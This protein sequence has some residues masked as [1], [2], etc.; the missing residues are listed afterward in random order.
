MVGKKNITSK[1]DLKN[2]KAAKKKSAGKD[3]TTF[4]EWLAMAH[5]YYAKFCFNVS[6]GDRSSSGKTQNRGLIYF[7]ALPTNQ[8]SKGKLRVSHGLFIE[9]A[10]KINGEDVITREQYEWLNEMSSN[11]YTSVIAY[12]LEDAQ[13]VFLDYIQPLTM[14][15][16]EK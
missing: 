6:C 15:E 2:D 3:N 8:S 12:N 1:M 10:N 16:G 9:I 4:S 14:P 7:I 13:S 5:G 11:G